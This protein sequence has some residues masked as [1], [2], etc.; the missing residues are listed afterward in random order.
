MFSS[1]FL[2]DFVERRGEKP[3]ASTRVRICTYVC[4]V[5]VLCD[6]VSSGRP[7]SSYVDKYHKM[8]KF[9]V[10]VYIRRVVCRQVPQNNKDIPRVQKKAIRLYVYVYMHTY[11]IQNFEFYTCAYR[12]KTYRRIELVVTFYVYMR[13]RTKK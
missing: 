10:L 6:P 9:V 1:N 7:H 11:R 2:S 5:F 13:I 3:S 12:Q 4:G 8:T